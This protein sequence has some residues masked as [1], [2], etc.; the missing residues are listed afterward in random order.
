[1][2]EP[3]EPLVTVHL[4]GFP[5]RVHA[6]AAEHAA[7]LRREFQL[8]MEQVR[9]HA[10]GVPGRLVEVSTVLSARYEGFTAE[11]NA[12]IDQAIDAGKTQIDLAFRL[13]AHAGAASAQMRAVLDDADAFCREG[14]LLTLATP[15]DLVAYRG[16][17]LD[18]FEQQCAGGPATPWTGALD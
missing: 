1:M 9:D 3:T 13:P 4:L 17:Y 2:T 16:W 11:Q 8:I 14:R 6:R 5:V 7:D 10:D 18:N 12:L 15:D